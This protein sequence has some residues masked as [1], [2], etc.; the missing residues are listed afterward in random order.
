MEKLA[1]TTIGELL[2][3]MQ[4]ASE[5]E[6]EDL[7]E[8]FENLIQNHPEKKILEALEKSSY[9]GNRIY[10]GESKFPPPDLTEDGILLT[11]EAGYIFAEL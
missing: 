7:K 4:T 10:L 11:N 3:K 8:E 6:K 2:L 9:F 5:K 1:N